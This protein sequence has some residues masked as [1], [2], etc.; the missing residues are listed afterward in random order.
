MNELKIFFLLSLVPLA[1]LSLEVATFVAV[2]GLI[3]FFFFFVKTENAKSEK[4]PKQGNS[5]TDKNS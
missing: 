5:I 1:I 3:V 2:V 4:K